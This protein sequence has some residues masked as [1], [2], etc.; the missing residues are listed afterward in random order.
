VVGALLLG[1]AGLF[2]SLARAVYHTS[3]YLWTVER[4]RAPSVLETRVPEP[5]ARALYRR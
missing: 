4:E 3:L 1:C 2:N 5:L